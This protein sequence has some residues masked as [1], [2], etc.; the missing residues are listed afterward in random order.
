MPEIELAFVLVRDAHKLQGTGI[1]PGLVLTEPTAA[2]ERGADLV[3][4]AATPT[5][6]S[7]LAPRFLERADFCAFSCSALADRTTERAIRDTAARSG[8]RFFVPHGAVLALDGIADGR[9]LIQSVNITTTKSGKSLGV[10]PQAQGVLFE[11]PVREACRLFP[12]NVNVHAAIALAGI[13]FDQTTSRIVAQPGL[14][15]NEHRIQVSGT[16]F[17]WD[18][19]VSSRSLG[20]VT[21]S[22]TP[23]SA[24]GSLR[25]ILG[26]AGVTLV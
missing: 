6:V 20:G 23:L 25:R 22:Y 16:G 7:T 3:L 17:D 10:D 2:L 13:G 4:E 19:S 5:L 1:D 24:I 8:R 21:G 18:L 11:G 15:T 26:G 9:D 14:A 12:R